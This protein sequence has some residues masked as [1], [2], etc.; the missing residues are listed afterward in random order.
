MKLSILNFGV[1]A[2]HQVI[3]LL[4]N[5]GSNRSVSDYDAFLI[6]PFAQMNLGID[7]ATFE[8]RQREIR[9]LV[10]RKGGIVICLLRPPASVLVQTLGDVGCYALLDLAAAVPVTLVKGRIRNGESTRWTLRRG[11]NGVA[12]DYFRVLQRQVRVESFLEASVAE[13]EGA[14]GK[15]L[16]EDSTSYPV[17]VE[18]VVAAGR[19]CFVPFPVAVTDR[20]GAAVKRVVEAHFGG[21]S[22]I[23]PPDWVQGTV[24]PGANANDGLIQELQGKKSELE[25]QVS[26]LEKK[27]DELLGLRALLFGYGKS[28]LEPVVRKAFL[29]LGFVVPE[30]WDGDWDFELREGAGATVAIGEVEGTEGPVDRDKYRQL[31]EYFQIEVMEGRT[32]KA[33]LVGNGFRTKPLDAQE[34]GNQFTE[35]VLR[36]AAQNGFCLLPTTELFKAVCAVLANPEDGALK[37]EIRRSILTTVGMWAFAGAPVSSGSPASAEVASS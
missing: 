9:D 29:E 6:D 1:G 33:I 13:V 35:H 28:V 10:H 30:T 26:A 32:H 16:A 25:L 24:V 21:A 23:E 5:F 31:L 18:F 19:I 15:V 4:P 22:E 34:R 7:R 20:T 3:E 11:A 2:T 12:L 8:R 14:G 37:V 17:C 36:G 27:R